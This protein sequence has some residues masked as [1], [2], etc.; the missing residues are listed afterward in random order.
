MMVFVFPIFCKKKKNFLCLS[1]SNIGTVQGHNE[2]CGTRD[3]TGGIRDH[4]GGI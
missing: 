2:I 1:I 4:K 3:R